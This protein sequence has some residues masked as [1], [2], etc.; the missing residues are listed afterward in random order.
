MKRKSY[1]TK[2]VLIRVPQKL[3]ID[4]TLNN[5]ISLWESKGWLFRN[6]DLTYSESIADSDI[7]ILIEFRKLC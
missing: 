7:Q 2:F 4:E 1:V 5:C 3:T 6:K